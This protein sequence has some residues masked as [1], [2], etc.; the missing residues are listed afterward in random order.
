MIL[1]IVIYDNRRRTMQETLSL[2]R[3]IMPL[4]NH[5]L[6]LSREICHFF[7]CAEQLLWLSINSNK[8]DIFSESH[9]CDI[10]WTDWCDSVDQLAI[11]GAYR[12]DIYIP[13]AAMSSNFY[14]RL[15]DIGSDKRETQLPR[16]SGARRQVEHSFPGGT[17]RTIQSRH[18]LGELA[19]RVNLTKLDLP[20][21]VSRRNRNRVVP[22][23]IPGDFYWSVLRSRK[24]PR[25][26][27]D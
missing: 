15:L 2:L 10:S 22:L 4:K 11:L 7:L 18:E 19:R 13:R 23:R 25:G 9:R 17:Y 5:I 3:F 16:T 6:Y 24:R 8:M 12:I 21:C 20:C 26:V 27:G 14:R 1:I